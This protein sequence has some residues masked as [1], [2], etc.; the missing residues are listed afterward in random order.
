MLAKEEFNGEV[1]TYSP[2]FKDDE[3]EKISKISHHLVFNSPSQL[4][5]YSKKLKR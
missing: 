4:K 5:K 1:H 3:I 2:A